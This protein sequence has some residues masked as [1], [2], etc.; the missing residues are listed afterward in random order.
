PPRAGAGRVARRRDGKPVAGGAVS[1]PLGRRVG[2]GNRHPAHATP[3]RP[4]RRDGG[5]GAVAFSPDGT[6]LATASGDG[7]VL[8]WDATTGHPVRDLVTG[9]TNGVYS[10]GAVAFSPDGK[11]LASGGI[12][13][14]GRVW[15]LA[16]A[17]Q[18]R[19]ALTRP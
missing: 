4:P 15:R 3:P 11:T 6:T 19:T 16:P 9:H 8:L 17:P 13:G 14:T 2:L 1:A 7:T 18:V 12:S 10:V 5:I